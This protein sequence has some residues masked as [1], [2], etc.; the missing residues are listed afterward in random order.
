MGEYVL[1][2]AERGK[3]LQNF[4]LLNNKG[5]RHFI[6]TKRS[7]VSNVKIKFR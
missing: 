2:I 3:Y 7:L 6:K 4:E 5:R 1:Q